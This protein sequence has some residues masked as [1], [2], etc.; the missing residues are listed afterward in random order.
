ME[1]EKSFLEDPFMAD[2]LELMPG[3][4]I[5]YS[6][7]SEFEKYKPFYYQSDNG[8][9]EIDYSIDLCHAYNYYYEIWENC[10]MFGIPGG[11]WTKC[12]PW[13]LD[14]IKIFDLA[15]AETDVYFAKKGR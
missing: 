8:M 1:Y 12:Q 13:I 15:K 7:L 5:E 14:L 9:V 4:V 11:D 6:Q 3:G 10:K 2:E